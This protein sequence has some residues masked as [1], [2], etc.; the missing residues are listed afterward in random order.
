MCLWLGLII[1]K[2]LRDGKGHD[3]GYRI[4]LKWNLRTWKCG[5]RDWIVSA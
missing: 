3:I 2:D 1:W 4:T 5:V